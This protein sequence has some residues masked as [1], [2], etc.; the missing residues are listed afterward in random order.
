[1]KCKDI[2][3]CISYALL[4]YISYY[5][6]YPNYSHA[7]DDR[8][9]YHLYSNVIWQIK[10]NWKR[11]SI[12]P[13]SEFQLLSSAYLHRGFGSSSYSS[14]ERIDRGDVVQVLCHATQQSSRFVEPSVNG[15]GLVMHFLVGGLVKTSV[16]SIW[17]I[18]KKCRTC[19]HNNM[20]LPDLKRA[21][22]MRCILPPFYTTTQIHDEC[23]LQLDSRV[24]K[25]GYI[26]DCDTSCSFSAST[27]T[28]SHSTTTLQGGTF[29]LLTRILGYPP[30]R[31]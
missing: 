8:C 3:A 10:L 25:V 21:L 1:M 18:V 15:N 28:V 2:Y 19:Q 7:I 31:S 20:Q 26:H 4:C 27:S 13:T 17:L 23:Y 24:R 11:P 12:W 30:H 29:F 5:T 22:I 14:H 6:L 9:I 16:G